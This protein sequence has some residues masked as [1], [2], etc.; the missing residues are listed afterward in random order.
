MRSSKIYSILE[1]FDKYEQNRFRKYLCSPYFNKDEK[2]IALFEI[3]LHDINSKRRHELE[4]INLW[5]Q[6]TPSKKYDDVRFRKYCSDLLK[7]LEG[8]LALQVYESNPLHQA[9]YLMD[10]V[11]K[12]KMEKLYNSTMKTARR[13]SDQQQFKPASYYY[14]QYEVEKNFYDLLDYEKKR[15]VRTNMEEIANNLDYFYLAE[16]LRMY[17]AVLVQQYFASQEYQLLFIDE[18]LSHIKEINLEEVPPVAIYYQIYLTITEKD[19]EEHYYRLKELLDQHSLTFPQQ[20][21]LSLYYFAINYCIQRINLGFQ[22]FSGEFFKIYSDL[23]DKEIIFV[24]NELSPWDFKNIIV[25]ALRLG[26]FDWTENFIKK[27]SHKLP[28]ESRENAVTYNLAQLYFYQK[29]YDE[30]IRQLSNVEYEDVSYNLNSKTMLIAT[31]YETDELIPLYSLFDSFNAYLNRN[32]RI[33]DD[34]KKYYKN[35]IKYTKKITKLPPGNKAAVEKLK[36][37]VSE[38]PNIVNINWLKQK[39]AELE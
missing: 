39:I 34:R 36:K 16:K 20:E 6:L 2:L 1:H 23:I 10:A 32:R 4:K 21:A 18:I 29:K 7:L 33:P 24:N 15:A 14:Y 38:T 35:L 8:F 27:Y 3:L 9:T 5:N 37:E 30:V 12:K 13:L 19:K 25:N 26:K 31:Y 28:E 22:K 17:C 11:G